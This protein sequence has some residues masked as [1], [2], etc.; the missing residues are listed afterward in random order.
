MIVEIDHSHFARKGDVKIVAA[1]VGEETRQCI[2]DALSPHGNAR[3]TNEGNVRFSPHENYYSNGFRR[4]HIYEPEFTKKHY[5]AV[6]FVKTIVKHTTP[7]SFGQPSVT[8]FKE[9]TGREPV[10]TKGG[11]IF[12]FKN[13]Q[14][15]I[16]AHGLDWA[17]S[18]EPC[19]KNC[20]VEIK[21]MPA[22]GDPIT[23]SVSK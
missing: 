16:L 10:R 13:I 15:V 4:L 18:S 12:D 8:S 17:Y 11:Y 21:M 23:V 6:E 2:L 1:N 9:A 14:E 5:A 19:L 20:K 7:N 22:V 3:K